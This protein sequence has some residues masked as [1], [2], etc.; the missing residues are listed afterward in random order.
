ML[1]AA[2]HLLLST[3]AGA[4]PSALA[5]ILSTHVQKTGVNY[6]ALAADRAPLTAYLDSL[7]AADL[8]GATPAEKMAF[9]INAYNAMTLEVMAEE[10]P[11][12]SI[13]TI[14]FG[15]AW[16]T[17]KRRLAGEDRTLDAIEHQLLRPMGDARIH[18]AIVCAS[19]GCPP[20][21]TTVYNAS[22]LDAQLDAASR[23]WVATTAATLNRTKKHISLSRIF[24][25]FGEDFTAQYA[26]FDI[27]GVEGTRE[28]AL[29]FVATY[30]SPKDRVWIRSGDYGLALARYDWSVNG[31]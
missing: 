19:K 18:A 6:T 31:R 14:D 12:T 15:R 13:L 21:S 23:A 20:L 8:S 10:W 22:E 7:A 17:R 3:A 24:E 30:S 9:W 27:P 16:K 29:N 2:L 1:L 25:W 26:T 4:D 28:A 11:V 5:P